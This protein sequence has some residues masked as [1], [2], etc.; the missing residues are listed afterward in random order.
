MQKEIA[1]LE[2]KAEANINEDKTKMELPEASLTGL[3]QDILA[4]LPVKPG[5]NGTRI[6][7][8]H[9]KT[10]LGPMLKLVQN[11]E[12][13]RLIDFAHSNINRDN[14]VPIIDRLVELRQEEALLLGY[15][16]YSEMVLEGRMAK[17]PATV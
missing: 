8:L 5:A 7:P 10:V 4:K 2:S 16:S 3:P 11:E 6:I 9:E 12:T 14:N 17:N 15:S 13:R 1:D